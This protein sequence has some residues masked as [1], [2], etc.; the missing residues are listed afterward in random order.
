MK[1]RIKNILMITALIITFSACNKKTEEKAE[2]KIKES[3]VL[4]NLKEKTLIEEEYILGKN[5]NVVSVKDEELILSEFL[6]GENNYIK[7]SGN[8]DRVFASIKEK[9]YYVSLEKRKDDKLIVVGSSSFNEEQKSKTAVFIIGKDG[10]IEKTE[11]EGFD[12]LPQ[13]DILNDDVILYGETIKEGKMQSFIAYFNLKDK[14]MKKI[15]SKELQVK[16]DK[17]SGEY[18]FYFSFDGENIYYQK[19]DYNDESFE[20]GG[21]SSIHRIK[22]YKGDKK[23]EKVINVDKKMLKFY[24]DDDV[25]VT[26]DYVFENPNV[27]SGTLYVKKG[28]SYEKHIIPEVTPGNDISEIYRKDDNLYLITEKNLYIYNLKDKNYNIMRY[29]EDTFNTTS[30]FVDGYFVKNQHKE[31]KTVAYF[32]KL[33]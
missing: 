22:D 13:A 31:D 32:Y 30:S 29:N 24:V 17:V 9:G 1:R 5:L 2:F 6:D 16:R 18:I 7:K 3:L 27:D 19:V 4:D 20:K 8:E 33:K 14:E 28:G 10:S 12:K 21:R 11:L 26:S 25:V 23:V 15:V